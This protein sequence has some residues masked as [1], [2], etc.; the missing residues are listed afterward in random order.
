[1][2]SCSSASLCVIGKADEQELVP[3]EFTAASAMAMPYHLSASVLVSP[4]IEDTESA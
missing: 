4:N 1:M 2:S 3:T